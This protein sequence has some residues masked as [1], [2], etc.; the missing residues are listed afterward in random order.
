MLLGGMGGGR[1]TSRHFYP[2]AKGWDAC[3]G[4]CIRD[5]DPALVSNIIFGSRSLRQALRSGSALAA[6]NRSAHALFIHQTPPDLGCC[7]WLGR[8]NYR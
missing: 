5:R 1:S 6:L 4:L 3:A 2:A 7:L 8:E